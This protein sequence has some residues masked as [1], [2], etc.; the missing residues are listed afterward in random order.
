MPKA[1]L[2]IASAGRAPA[3]VTNCIQRLEPRDRRLVARALRALE[4]SAVYR[5]GKRPSGVAAKVALDR[6]VMF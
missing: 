1:R 5:R 3:A 2:K 4:D 6:R